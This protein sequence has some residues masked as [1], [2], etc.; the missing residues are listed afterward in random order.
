M[1]DVILR[2]P[3]ADDGW[4]LNRLVDASPPLDPNS[5]YC[6][7]LQ[8]SHFAETS[9]A[10]ERHGELLGF[11]SAYRKP[12]QSDIL[13]VW[14][15][16]VGHSARG[17]G[18]AKAMLNNLV[19]RDPK[20]LFLETTITRD[21]L[22]SRALFSRFARDLNCALEELPMFDERIH[23]NGEHASEFLIRLGPIP[24]HGNT[25]SE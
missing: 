4:Q 25:T 6:N 9:V 14:Q 1:A 15:V 24:N 20:P 8:C 13:F 7:L 22:A 18:L 11:I 23:F 21:N 3:R 16:V 17:Q 2:Q 5:V 10:A 19:S 12:A